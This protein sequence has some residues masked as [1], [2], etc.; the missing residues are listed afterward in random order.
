MLNTIGK[1]T[2]IPYANS[3]LDDEIKNDL[4]TIDAALNDLRKFIA[5]L[6]GIKAIRQSVGT[7]LSLPGVTRW[8]Y[9][10][11]MLECF[12]LGSDEIKNAIKKHRPELLTMFEQV[13]EANIPLFNAHQRMLKLVEFRIRNLEV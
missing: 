13:Y 10:L 8:V 5:K 9:C 4:K 2:S 11:T 12:S 1:R 6:K 3:K 7:A